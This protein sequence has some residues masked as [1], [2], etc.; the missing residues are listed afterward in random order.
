MM[1]IITADTVGGERRSQ[2]LTT[3]SVWLSRIAVVAILTAK[4]AGL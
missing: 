2:L 4:I 1:R 3:C